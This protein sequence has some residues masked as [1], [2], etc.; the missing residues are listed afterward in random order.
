MK[1]TGKK[2]III[3]AV[4]AVIAIVCLTI[5]MVLIFDRYEPDQETLEVV[6]EASTMLYHSEIT[7]E[8]E[9]IGKEK[10]DGT[11][12]YKFK[13]KLKSH[14][15]VIFEF[16]KDLKDT[17]IIYVYEN[18]VKKAVLL[19]TSDVNEL[20]NVGEWPDEWSDELSD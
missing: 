7:D 2:P 5:A 17:Y 4:T 1:K 11:T 20:D 8:Y 16:A 6:N 13:F 9:Q 15:E 3:I 12:F 10:I 14:Q 18:D 19:N